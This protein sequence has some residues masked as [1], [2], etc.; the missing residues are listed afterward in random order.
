LG[1]RILLVDDEPDV[2]TSIAL[3]LKMEGYEVLT[4]THGA[5]ALEMLDS[6]LPDIVIC[7]FMMPWM[8]GRELIL[9]LKAREDTRDIP[10]IMMSG[11]TPGEP[12]P[13]DAFLR[14]PMDITELLGTIERLL[15]AGSAGQAAPRTGEQASG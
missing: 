4:A 13:W 9:Q 6:P 10:T 3:I 11:V 15:L 2:R 14:K 7:D 8:N 1:K 5:A 12:E